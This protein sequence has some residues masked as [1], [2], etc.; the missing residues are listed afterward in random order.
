MYMALDD[1][2]G[3][4]IAFE[5]IDFKQELTNV[6]EDNT[7]LLVNI[8]QAQL[9]SGFDAEGKAVQATIYPSYS[10][11]TIKQKKK[12]GVDLGAVTD[13]VTNY[14]TGAMYNSMTKKVEGDNVTTD[15]NV[16]YFA[17]RKQWSGE[18]A[19]DL[20]ESYRREF[21]EEKVIPYIQNI[22]N[23]VFSK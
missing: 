1:L 15:S 18:K 3:K 16:G 20:N 8:Q 22:V 13:R 9:A 14:M 7:E 21:A 2:E 11:Y 6:I 10:P 19:F 12:Y 4:I 23:V 17:E 5:A